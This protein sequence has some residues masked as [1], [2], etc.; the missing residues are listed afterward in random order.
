MEFQLKV[1]KRDKEGHFI[2]IDGKIHQQDISILNIYTPN[3]RSPTFIRETVLKLKSHIET[4]T[5]M[6]GDL[7]ILHSPMDSLCTE[8]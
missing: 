2:L 4:P 6:V 7:N 1:I 3:A 5:L 8:K